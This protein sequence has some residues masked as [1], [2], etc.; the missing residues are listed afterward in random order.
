MEHI[1]IKN[2]TKILGLLK[3][4]K[5]SKMTSQKITVIIDHKFDREK[6]ESWLKEALNKELSRRPQ[7]SREVA[8]Q[9]TAQRN[10]GCFIGD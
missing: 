2:K 9:L 3:R 10:V 5:E 8:Q 6:C 4:I 7:N 1:F